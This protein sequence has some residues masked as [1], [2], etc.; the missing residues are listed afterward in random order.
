MDDRDR[1]R[2]LAEIHVV[3]GD[4]VHN[5]QI[6]NNNQI[7]D[8][9]P[10]EDDGLDDASLGGKLGKNDYAEYQ[11][12]ANT[13]SSISAMGGEVYDRM[14]ARQKSPLARNVEEH[15]LRCNDKVFTAI[16]NN[17][18]Y[19]MSEYLK[20]ADYMATKNG[21]TYLHYLALYDR[22]EMV[23]SLYALGNFGRLLKVRVGRE[24]NLD[25]IVG[26]SSTEIAK[27]MKHKTLSKIIK[28]HIEYEKSL[29]GLH[30]AARD[31][32][33]EKITEICKA[34]HAEE[35]VDIRGSIGNTPF[36]CACV[37]GKLDAVKTLLTYGANINCKNKW[38]DTVLHRSARWGQYEIVKFLLEHS[39]KDVDSTNVE[40]S[41]PLHMAAQYGSIPTVL[42]LLE[43]GAN[44]RTRNVKKMWL[45]SD[46]AK[47]G[48]HAR[49]FD[50]LKEAEGD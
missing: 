50:I 35:S 43:F 11:G 21:L 48:K 39:T 16:E 40:G 3:I 13:L 47:D 38:G 20:I 37:S 32:D 12:E 26:K 41:T 33:V 18:I 2:D 36:Y 49:V 9:P 23:A 7:G 22:P 14:D 24:S 8:A 25:D 1:N 34:D 4:N 42:K 10:G 29:S 27:R 6:G 5:V 44:P 46:Y 45:P 15:R 17:D 28:R 19:N 30:I 31:G